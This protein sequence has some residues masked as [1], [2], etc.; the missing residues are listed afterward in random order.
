MANLPLVTL[1][2][3]YHRKA[4]QITINF[5]YNEV[6][7]KLLRA[8]TEAKWSKN[9]KSWYLQNNPNNLKVIFS[10]FKGTA[11]IDADAIFNTKMPSKKFPKKRIRQLNDDNRL[12]LNN[13]Y[14]YLKGKRY[15]DN[16]VHT[17]T[18]L[19]ADFIEFYN[20]EP[21][22]NLNNRS[23]EHYIE[24]I[25]IKRNYAINTQ[26]QFISS[27]KLFVVFYQS[28]KINDLQLQRPKKSRQL[29]NV[30][31]Q[32]EVIKLLQVTKNLKHR[33]ALALIYSS[34]LRISELIN[35]KI[36]D[37]HID[38]QQVFI[39]CSKGKKDRYVNLAQSIMPLLKNYLMTYAPKTYVIEGQNGL[40]YS[41]SSIR[42]FLKSSCK[43]A[44]IRQVVTPHTLRHSYATHLL[45]QGVNLRHI[46]ELLGHA[47]PETTMVYTHVAR[48]DL[49]NIESPLDKAIKQL[50]AVKKPEDKFLLSRNF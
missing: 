37:L 29:P 48:K 35:L 33:M 44:K 47:R 18:Q 26:R 36:E 16:T 11:E 23:V 7:I 17:Y 14:K 46:Q 9:L 12:L 15:S 25:Y 45:E 22:E 24:T 39:S 4:H 20:D 13:F 50:D 34:G 3:Q 49:L 43:L 21:I 19:V 28:S 27:L 1:K 8:K 38:R 32:L 5:E 2:P 30:L 40:K 42:K 31:S 6:L 10:T 41:D